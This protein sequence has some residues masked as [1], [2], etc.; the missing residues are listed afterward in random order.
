[1]SKTYFSMASRRMGWGK[2]S[3]S[4]NAGLSGC[5][6]VPF[7]LHLQGDRLVDVLAG[8]PRIELY[9][10]VDCKASK[11]KRGQHPCRNP[12]VD[13]MRFSRELPRDD[14]KRRPGLEQMR[15]H[16]TFHPWPSFH[17]VPATKV[18]QSLVQTPTQRHED[19]AIDVDHESGSPIDLDLHTAVAQPV[20]GRTHRQQFD[21]QAG[22]PPFQ[23]RFNPVG[24]LQRQ[25]GAAR[26]QDQR[27][28][29]QEIPKS[30]LL[31]Q[32][33]YCFKLK[34]RRTVSTS[35][36]PSGCCASDFNCVTGE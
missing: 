1:M 17:K 34:M 29:C 11:L 22:D 27:G 24:L 28:S 19:L 3:S 25:R 6:E 26:G 9:D 36:S 21:M 23:F 5:A 32:I 13:H 7:E 18:S 30:A 12:R 8:Q 31:F 15:T 4:A 2:F 14:S 16:Q 35:R 10:R 20:A 33:P